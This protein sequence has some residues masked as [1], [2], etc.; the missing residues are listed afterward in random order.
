MQF[1]PEQVQAVLQCR[2]ESLCVTSV[3]EAEH[4]IIGKTDAAECP[5]VR[6][7]RHTYTFTRIAVDLASAV[8]IAIACPFVD[9]MT[10][11]GMG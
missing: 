7:Q 4:K 2:Q 3:L 10:D 5:E 8:P 6:A 1:Q 11:S 9:P